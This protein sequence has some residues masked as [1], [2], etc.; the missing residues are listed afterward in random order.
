[1]HQSVGEPSIVS[2]SLSVTLHFNCK[3]TLHPPLLIM[4]RKTVS[5]WNRRMLNKTNCCM[6]IGELLFIIEC[7]LFGSKLFVDAA[8]VAGIGILQLGDCWLF[9]LCSST[10]PSSIASFVV[11]K[12]LFHLPHLINIGTNDA[13]KIKK[14]KKHCVS[15]CK[16]T[17]QTLSVTI[18]IIIK[19]L[20]ISSPV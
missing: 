6:S 5:L 10:V 3:C 1:M 18:F 17:D 9:M 2:M 12:Y 11:R 14:K 13:F 20:G 16:R 19:A 8:C 15:R 4:C 7:W